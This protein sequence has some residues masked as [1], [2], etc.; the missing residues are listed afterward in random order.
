MNEQAL[1]QFYGNEVMRESVHEFM[2][3][4]LREVAAEHAFAGQDTAGIYE[5]KKAVELTFTKLRELY[6]KEP[7]PETENEAR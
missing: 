7:K 3:E 6:S 4:A 2:I 1:A 5:A